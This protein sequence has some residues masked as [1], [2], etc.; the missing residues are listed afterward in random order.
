[1]AQ[2][3]THFLLKNRQ[4]Y[5]SAF[6][7]TL[8][9]RPRNISVP[10]SGLFLGRYTAGRLKSKRRWIHK[11]HDIDRKPSYLFFRNLQNQNWKQSCFQVGS[12][13]RNTLRSNILARCIGS[14]YM[15]FWGAIRL[16][17]VVFSRVSFFASN[18][19]QL[20]VYFKKKFCYCITIISWT[21]CSL[22]LFEVKIPFHVSLLARTP[23]CETGL[24]REP[25]NSNSFLNFLY[26]FL[27]TWDGVLKSLANPWNRIQLYLQWFLQ[28]S[29]C[30]CCISFSSLFVRFDSRALFTPATQAYSVWK[31]LRRFFSGNDGPFAAER[32]RDTKR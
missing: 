11:Y 1:M 4:S 8:Y 25:T 19:R 2:E 14:R 29:L 13:P 30:L 17:L 21:S 24:G 7:V 16:R 3:I 5:S 12:S 32:S 27:L 10:T 15:L 31:S 20:L 26:F 22:T 23:V 9:T 6:S 18:L 28:A